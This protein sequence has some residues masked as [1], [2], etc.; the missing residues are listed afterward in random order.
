MDSIHCCIRFQGKVNQRVSSSCPINYDWGLV[1]FADH[2]SVHGIE[3]ASTL[4]N[5]VNGTGQLNCLDSLLVLIFICI[6][7]LTFS[8]LG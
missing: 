6:N 7:S 2:I 1:A 8:N 3:R 5:K 4:G